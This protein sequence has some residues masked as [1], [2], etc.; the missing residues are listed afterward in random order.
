MPILAGFCVVERFHRRRRG[1]QHS[2]SSGKLCTHYG[3][4][5]GVIARDFLLLIAVLMLFVDDDETDAF[6]G[7]KN[8]G[9]SADNDRGFAGVD[10]HPFVEPLT[11]G[12]RTMKDGGFSRKALRKAIRELRSQSDFRNEDE[13]AFAGRDEMLGRSH[14]NLGFTAA[15]HA[16]EK[17]GLKT[18]RV[19][20]G[21]ECAALIGCQLW[22]RSVTGRG[23][24]GAQARQRAALRR[25]AQARQRAALR[26]DRPYSVFRQNSR[27]KGTF[28]YFT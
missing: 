7:R 27:R 1:T 9:A 8:R 26:V 17:Y 15:S 25:G 3:R 28:Q 12:Q 5:A 21:I 14:V 13:G 19:A 16:V 23:G 4:I 24:R 22:G 2:R 10:T 11:F 18:A 20:N 6:Q